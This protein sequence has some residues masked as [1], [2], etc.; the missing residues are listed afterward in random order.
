MYHE[1]VKRKSFKPKEKKI[2]F[3]TSSKVAKPHLAASE[4]KNK[5]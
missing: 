2:N 3:I 1:R 4:T 5:N